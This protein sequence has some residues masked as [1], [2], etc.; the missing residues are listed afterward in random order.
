[1]GA[2][3]EA[4]DTRLDRRVA[5][6]VLRDLRPDAEKRFVREARA[7]AR[8]E[9]PGICQV[10]E[11]GECDGEPYI[12]MQ[13]I[14]GRS[15]AAVAPELPVVSVRSFEEQVERRFAPLVGWLIRRVDPTIVVTNEV[16]DGVIPAYPTGRVLNPE[17][18]GHNRAYGRNP[19]F[20]FI[21]RNLEYLHRIVIATRNTPL[22]RFGTPQEIADAICFMINNSAVSGELWADAGWHPPA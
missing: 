8:V 15:L 11:V 17:A 4:M 3:Y 12:V 18:T 2:V 7:Q 13:L 20:E 14:R 10:F 1:M 9:H 21:E 22:R 5:V 19:Y 6:K 16:G